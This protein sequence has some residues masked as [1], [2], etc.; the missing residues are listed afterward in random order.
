MENLKIQILDYFKG[1]QFDEAEHRYAVNGQQIKISVSGVI[2][3]FVEPFDKYTISARIAA[4]DGISQ[5]DV[6]K[7][8]ENEAQRACQN[9]KDTHLFGELYPFNRHIKPRTKFE[10]AIVNFW[11]D[12][13]STVIPVVMELQMYHK[14]YMFAGTAD[15]LLYNTVTKTFIIGDYK[16]NKDLFKNYKGKTLLNPFKNLLDTPYNKYQLQLSFYQIL[17]E[18]AGFKVSSRKLIWLK[19]DGSYL[20]YNTDDYTEILKEQLKIIKL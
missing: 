1:L 7:S 9:G 10:E 5:Q 15:I 18:Q 12:L 6:L 11:N 19:P 14:E 3:H 16:T 2:K 20:L 17:L 4:R 8:W 13:P